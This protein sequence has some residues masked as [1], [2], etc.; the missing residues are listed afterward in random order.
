MFES[1]L[2]DDPLLPSPNQLK[3]KILIKNKKVFK[4]SSVCQQQ[5]SQANSTTQL[6]QVQIHHSQSMVGNS[7][8][9]KGATVTSA[10]TP[11][12]KQSSQASKSSITAMVSPTA[13]ENSIASILKRTS[14][15]RVQ[16]IDEPT[17]QGE[18]ASDAATGN[19]LDE[20]TME[21]TEDHESNTLH[22]M[23]NDPREASQASSSGM[24]KM[25]NR[26]RAISTRLKSAEPRGGGQKKNNVMTS[27]IHKSKSLTD[28]AFHRISKSNKV[29]IKSDCPV[30]SLLASEKPDDKEVDSNEKNNDNNVA[31][32]PGQNSNNM[33]DANDD[34]TNSKLNLAE[35]IVPG[36]PT[37]LT[38]P[39]ASAS[40]STSMAGMS[41]SE[42]QRDNLVSAAGTAS[43]HTGVSS[44][45]I[46]NEID[47]SYLN[48]IRK[49]TNIRNNSLEIQPLLDSKLKKK[50]RESSLEVVSKI[51]TSISTELTNDDMQPVNTGSIVFSPHRTV[52][53]KKS[54]FAARNST[55]SILPLCMKIPS[56]F[57]NFLY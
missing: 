44:S 14:A 50:K 37:I 39:S 51:K 25:V 43:I 35:K 27:L 7:S 3:Y 19:Q 21:F 13:L 31:T 16:S 54:V 48:R 40:I 4:S 45:Q 24:L 36:S 38:N 1:D 6:H 29:N 41:T 2:I 57:S 22:N 20:N 49:R 55:N 5:T 17:I 56:I 30:G 33:L 42:N 9:G 28:S 23:V 46:K 26:I 15:N 52:I 32:S 12:K 8:V 53:Q 11:P 18:V 34:N 47:L 10:I